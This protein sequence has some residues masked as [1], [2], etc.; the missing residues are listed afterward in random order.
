MERQPVDIVIPVFNGY[1]LLKDCLKSVQA[2]TEP[3]Y[4]IWIGDDCSIQT[5]LL[6]F[7]KRINDPRITVNINKGRRG[8]PGNCN[9]TSA[10]GSAP[11][12]CLLNSDTRVSVGW[13]DAMMDNMADEEVGIVGSRLVYPRER[14]EHGDTIQHAG[15]ARNSE[16]LPYHIYRYYAKAAPEVMRRLKVNCVTFACVLIRRELWQQMGGLDEVFRLGQYDDVDFCWRAVHAGRSIVYEPNS[17]VYHYEHGSEASWNNT[18][19]IRNRNL[20]MERWGNLGSDEYLFAP[21]RQPHKS[22]FT[23]LWEKIEKKLDGLL[24]QKVEA[25]VTRLLDDEE[26]LDGAAENL[27]DRREFQQKGQS[28][29]ISEGDLYPTRKHRVGTYSNRRR[30]YR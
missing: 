17:M 1:G 22:D 29:Q 9:D 16:G 19:N 5:A 23:V 28:L 8:F 6:D 2:H 4:H 18:D 3:P 20:L 25:A 21:N 14:G 24:D 13:L 12:I 27:R 11:F 26:K 7:Y 10:L 15:V 30:Q